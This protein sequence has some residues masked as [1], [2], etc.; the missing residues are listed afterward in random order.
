MTVNHDIYCGW[1]YRLTYLWEINYFIV[2]I[3]I[4]FITFMSFSSMPNNFSNTLANHITNIS[5]LMMISR[6]NSDILSTVP[7]DGNLLVNLLISINCYCHSSPHKCYCDGTWIW[8]RIIFCNIVQHNLR[9]IILIS[10]DYYFQ[11]IITTSFHANINVTSSLSFLISTWHPT[12]RIPFSLFAWIKNSFCFVIF[13]FF[14]F[15][16]IL[17]PF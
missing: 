5:P 4:T 12:I 17:Y 15:I 2:E 6:Y 9:F 7:M 3:F 13:I 8:G 1:M 14:T 16:I 11:I 10:V